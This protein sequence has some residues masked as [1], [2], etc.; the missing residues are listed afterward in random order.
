MDGEAQT[1][2]TLRVG[3]A[4]AAPGREKPRRDP[5]C[6]N[7]ATLHPHISGDEVPLPRYCRVYRARPSHAW[8]TTCVKGGTHPVIR[9][10]EAAPLEAVG[11]HG[12]TAVKFLPGDPSGVMLAGDQP[13]L[14]V[15]GQPIGAVRRLLEYGHALP[16]RVLHAPVVMNIAEQQVAAF[17]PPDRSFG[18]P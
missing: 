8:A 13:A 10:V 17:L 6:R 5:V 7:S 4:S 12:E 14:E 9:P 11:D 3:D 16:R 2:V 1:W 15:S 18:G